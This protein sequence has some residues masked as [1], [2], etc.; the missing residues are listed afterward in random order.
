MFVV[1]GFMLLS[2]V[3]MVVLSR[4]GKVSEGIPAEAL[5]PAGAG[6]HSEP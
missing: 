3:L 4:S 2:S 1:G 6:H 5:D